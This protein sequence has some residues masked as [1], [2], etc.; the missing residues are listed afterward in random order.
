MTKKPDWLRI[1]E[2]K[3]RPSEPLEPPLSLGTRSNGEHLHV[4]RPLERRIRALA[5]AKAEENARRIGMDRRTFLASAA[6][7]ATTLLAVKIAGCSAPSAPGL[8][9]GTLDTN[10]PFVP[11]VATLDTSA[12]C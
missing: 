3:S 5:L 12:A 6:G 8:D 1:L 9:A 11:D 7:M 4:E 2:R 10:G